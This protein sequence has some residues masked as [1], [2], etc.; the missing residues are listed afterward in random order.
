MSGEI[1]N[2]LI[3]HRAHLR[4]AFAPLR[5]DRGRHGQHR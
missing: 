2:R 4:A 1:V 5:E 3:A